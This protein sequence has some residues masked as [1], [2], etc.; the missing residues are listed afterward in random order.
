LSPGKPKWEG[1]NRGKILRGNE[2]E[3]VGNTKN[4]SKEESIK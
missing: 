4:K 1:S 3:E 2:D